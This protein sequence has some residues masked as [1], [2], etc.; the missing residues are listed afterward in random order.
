MSRVFVIMEQ[1]TSFQK[2]R[3]VLNQW[4]DLNFLI[5]AFFVINIRLNMYEYQE[6][7]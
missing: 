6:F 7:L 3:V 5:S 1:F 4:N 2:A